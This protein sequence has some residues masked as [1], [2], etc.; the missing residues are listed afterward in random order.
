VSATLAT[1]SAVTN[2]QVPVL[3]ITGP[4]GVGKSTVAWKIF[5]ELVQA[6]TRVA[7]ADADQ[8]CMCY[9][10]PPGDR[11]RERIKA[12]NLGA[13]IPRYRAAGAQCV[14]VNGCLDPAGGVLSELMP[15]AEVTVCRLRADPGHVAGRFVGT[16]GAREG[17]DAMLE[18]ALAEAEAMDASNFA[19]VCVDTTGASVAEVADLV[20]EGCCDW[21]GFSG[22]LLSAGLASGTDIGGVDE[23]Q[24][25]GD[26][27]DAAGT[28]L[29]ICG[30]TGVGKSTVGF[31]LYV[32][33]VSDGFTAG[34]VDLDQIAFVRPGSGDD[35]DRHRLTAGNL[36]AMWRTYQS[37][38]ATHLIATG[39]VESEAAMRAYARALPAASVTVCRLHAGSDELTQRIM[40]RGDGGSWPQPGDPLRGKP[41]DYLRHVAK[42]AIVDADVL[43]RA[44]IGTVRVDTDGL[45]AAESADLIAAMTR[46]QAPAAREQRMNP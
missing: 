21:P 31:Q 24:P 18:E 29:L 4:A 40:S 20:R 23:A 3:W 9:P 10:A 38:G 12:Q 30:P 14:I 7:F 6:G 36:A 46:S 8:F 43:E 32:R 35:S 41:S 34:Y 42:R 2:A 28:V 26:M 22:S 27:D 16:E 33:C 37:A 44:G 11:T 5:T 13:L 19:D 15:Q 45:T 25:S 17:L 1:I 39:Q